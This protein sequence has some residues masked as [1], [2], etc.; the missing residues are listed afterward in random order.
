M[1]APLSPGPLPA[2]AFRVGTAAADAD[3]RIIYDPATG[4]I[5]FDNDG[6][7]AAVQVLFAVLDNAPA[8]LSASDFFVAA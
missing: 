8:N 6:T 3:D 1:F 2:S 5:W 4:Q 7:G